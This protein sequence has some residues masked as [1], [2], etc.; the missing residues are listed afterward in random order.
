MKLGEPS[1]WRGYV[2][3][4]RHKDVKDIQPDLENLWIEV[5]GRNKHSKL[6]LWVI[7]RSTKFMNT[8]SWLD[9]METLLSQISACWDGLLVI[10]R[11]MNIYMNID[12]KKQEDVVTKKYQNLLDVFNLIQIVSELTRTT[13]SSSTIIDHITTNDQSKITRTGIIP[14]S[15]V[16]DHD[17]PYVCIN[18]RS[19][20]LEPR[21]KKHENV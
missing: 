5:A 8:Q 18:I 6:L 1:K 16:S 11:D 7:Y 21:F 12:M 14:C 17:G 9:Q 3:Y 19:T 4:K 10:T 13:E 2:H 15:T 20:Q